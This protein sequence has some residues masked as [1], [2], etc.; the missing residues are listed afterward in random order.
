[1]KDEDKTNKQ[2]ISEL[3]ALHQQVA[4]LEKS[5]TVR[6]QAEG[7]L[8]ESEEKFRLSFENANIAMCIV[9]LDER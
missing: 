1:M 7:K 4:E 3:E 2:L 5:E 8:R 9:G 6:R